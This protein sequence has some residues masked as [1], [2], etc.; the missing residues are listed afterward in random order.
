[1]YKRNNSLGAF[2]VISF[3]LLTSATFSIIGYFVFSHWK[4]SAEQIIIKTQNAIDVNIL[5]QIE[6][7]LETPLNINKVYHPLIEN[8]IVNIT[9]KEAREQFFVGVIKNTGQEVYSFS[10]GMENG[11]YYGARRNEQNEIEIIEN[12]ASTQGNSRYFSVSPN[13]TAQTLVKETAKFD[14]RTRDWYKIA[15]ETHNPGFS[16]IYKHFVVNDLALSVARPVYDGTGSL[17]GVLGTHITLSKINDY[18]A[19]LTKENRAAAYIIEKNSGYLVA[20]SLGMSNF[21]AGTDNHMRRLAIDEIDNIP[22]L[23]AYQNYQKDAKNTFIVKTSNDKLYIKITEYNRAGLD[24]L[25][26]TAV[27]EGPFIAGITKSIRIS[28]IVSILA[29]IAAI[30]LY[31][32]STGILLKPI[33]DLISTTERFSAGD[34]SQRAKIFRHDE[35]G[36]LSESF[37][38]MAEQMCVFINSLED[39]VKARTAELEKTMH[40]LKSSEENIRILLDST[41]EAIYG[42]DMQGICTFCN[43]SCLKLLNYSHPDDMIG[44][45]IHMLLHYKRKDGTPLPENECKV[46]NAITKGEGI[47]DDDAVIWRADGTSFPIEYSSYPQYR[48]GKI[49][50]AVVTFTDISKRKKSEAEILYLSYHDQLTGL[51]NRRYFEQELK[52]MDVPRNLP[53]TIVMADMNGLKLVNDSFGHAVGDE[54][55]KK[56]AAVIA[57]GCRADDIVARLGGDEFVILF[58]KTDSF[59]AEQIIKRIKDIAL[60]EKVAAVDLSISFGCATKLNKAEDIQELLKKAEDQ[61]YKKKLFE[62]PSMR[63]K[64]IKAIIT[65]VHEK[66]KREEAHSYRVSD[67]CKSMGEAMGLPGGDVEEL[68]AAGLLHDIGKIAIAESI[69][70][71]PGKLTEEEWEEMKRHPE[72]GYRILSTVNETSEMAEYVLAHHERWDGKGYPKG[73]QGE[74]IPLQ[75]RILAIADAYDAL[76]SERDYRKKLGHDKVVDELLKNAGTQFDPELTN[77]FITKVLPKLSH[78]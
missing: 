20:N 29:I 72:I 2:I 38:R 69:L 19:E 15:K 62:S 56:V 54:L 13:M 36:K 75:A 55:L 25:V 71:N 31:M 73:L 59:E 77:F 61:M 6:S 34:L 78:D 3:I 27:P 74:E 47:H 66:N 52:R 33:H 10:Y 28:L 51:F 23:D 4:S 46:L 16:P 22:I 48:H 44:K 58:P 68:K 65:T 43:A 24:W 37:N 41:A 14:P 35:I 76:T 32:K 42:I 45:N 5:S 30:F 60:K 39:K 50:G 57:K 17:E 9:D 70:H 1:M 8:G 64:T 67:I 40:E 7:F 18:L 12:N 49:I 53:L 11:D 63:G 21:A 26:I